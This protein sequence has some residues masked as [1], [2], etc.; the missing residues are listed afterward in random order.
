MQPHPIWSKQVEQRI[1]NL[2]NSDRSTLFGMSEVSFGKR[3]R[4]TPHLLPTSEANWV[5]SH[6]ILKLAPSG[7]A[8]GVIGSN[9]YSSSNQ[10]LGRGT[11]PR[12]PTRGITGAVADYEQLNRCC[13]FNIK[14]PQS[15]IHAKTLTVLTRSIRIPTSAMKSFSQIP[16]LRHSEL[17]L[18]SQEITD[19]IQVVSKEV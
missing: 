16:K 2:S 17:P 1:E 9:Q 10:S 12:D 13:W 7:C 19:S 5:M 11:N 18:W 14:M 6:Q 3:W 15:K 4:M 8:C